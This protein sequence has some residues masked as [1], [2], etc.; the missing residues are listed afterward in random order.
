MKKRNKLKR[1]T[2]EIAV[3]GISA[4]LI[5]L[6]L[7]LSVI[8]RYG[9][10]SFYIAAAV[11]L[12]VPICKKYY[13]AAAF[14][15]ISASLLAFAIVGDILQILGF[16]IYFGPM[17]FISTIMAE[18]NVKPYITFPVK[19]VY[20]NACLAALYYGSKTLFVDLSQL[21]LE[22]HYA[23]IAIV[24]T[25]I[26]LLLDTIM[27]MLYIRLKPIIDKA[28]KDVPV[29]KKS[30]E[31]RENG[32]DVFDFDDNDEKAEP[33][34]NDIIDRTVAN[35]SDDEKYIDGADGEDAISGEN[36]TDEE[37]K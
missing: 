33:S 10:V 29:K 14:A 31:E 4:G 32:D 27:L 16:L 9:T 11:V 18:K 37:K 2:I 5:L 15:Y 3:A 17:T 20:I 13:W 6:L 26:L 28:I 21:G 12:M 23:V 35:D 36:E 30:T 25:I 8:V 24:G 22:I 7:W 19:I 1:Q 34:Q